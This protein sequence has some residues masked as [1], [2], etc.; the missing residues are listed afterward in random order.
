MDLT[1]GPIAFFWTA[2][3]VR[4]FYQRLAL[5]PARRVVIGEWV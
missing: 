4:D 5:T 3:Q 1:I 2:D